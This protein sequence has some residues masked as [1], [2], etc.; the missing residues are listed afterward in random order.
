MNMYF[1]PMVLHFYFTCY[2]R[3][4]EAFVWLAYDYFVHVVATKAF[5]PSLSWL[6]NVRGHTELGTIG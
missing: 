5:H 4:Y 3:L 1:L 2:E 6:E